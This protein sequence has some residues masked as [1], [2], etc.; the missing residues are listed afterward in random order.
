M[1]S[2]EASNF[3]VLGGQY[4]ALGW[5]PQGGLELITRDV[6]LKKPY[7]TILNLSNFG[8]EPMIVICSY[9][10]VAH[11]QEYRSCVLM[12]LEY[13]NTSQSCNSNG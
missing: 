6:P 10:F 2:L 12:L 1:M 13:I 9:L 3:V 4:V 5:K 7:N 8:N 11:L